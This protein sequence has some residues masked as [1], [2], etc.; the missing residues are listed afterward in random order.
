M[1]AGQV[2]LAVFGAQAVFMAIGCA[3]VAGNRGRDRLAWFC[4][5]LIFN[6]F[7]LILVRALDRVGPPPAPAPT[8]RGSLI[9]CP[10]C[11]AETPA[12]MKCIKCGAPAS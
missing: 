1:D 9:A 3:A 11:G 7:A 6:V 10:S 12:G 5:G 4:L 2:A 8:R